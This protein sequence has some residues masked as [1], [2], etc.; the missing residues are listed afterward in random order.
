ML[1]RL[2]AL[3]VVLGLAAPAAAS[4]YSWPQAYASV[5]HN[6]ADALA[7]EPLEPSTYDTAT[8]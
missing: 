8:H 5:A 6:P 4:A 3:V 1:V 2:F 7:D